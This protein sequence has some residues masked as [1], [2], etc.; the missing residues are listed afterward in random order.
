MCIRDRA[1]EEELE[2]ALLKIR[3]LME[4]LP[5]CSKCNRILD[6]TGHWTSLEEYTSKRGEKQPSKT[7]CPD[8]SADSHAGV[9]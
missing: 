4:L 3:V 5:V 9:L 2:I 8:C 6:E 7:I 1:I